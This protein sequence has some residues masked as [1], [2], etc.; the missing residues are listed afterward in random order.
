MFGFRFTALAGLVALLASSVAGQ[1]QSNDRAVILKQLSAADLRISSLG[2]RLA[3]ANSSRCAKQMPGTGL[4]LHSIDQYRGPWRVAAVRL[5]GAIGGTSIAEVVAQSPSALAGI[6]PGDE[7]IA[8]NAA[9]LDGGIKAKSG[10]TNR[11]DRAEDRLVNLPAQDHIRLT[12]VRA[13]VI[14]ELVLS[15]VP[16]CRVRFEVVA[17]SARF[18]RTD[19]RLIQIGQELARTLSDEEIAVVLAHELAHAILN[20]RSQLALLEQQGRNKA[21]AKQRAILA[22]DF[23]DQA[24]RMSVW[25][26]AGA[27]F[28]PAAGPR[29][30]RNQ[31]RGFDSFPSATSAHRSA[32]ERAQMMD[33]EITRMNSSA[34]R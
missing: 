1:A 27:G 29:F 2:F 8:I 25:L 21:A 31:G 26:L 11:R 22:R 10:T 13:G 23:E 7:L 6:L 12:V 19:G 3:V 33:D 4:I 9:P 15:P 16:A 20:H 34:A 18:A 5:F 32:Q 28:D 14:K 24:D 30:M 17:G